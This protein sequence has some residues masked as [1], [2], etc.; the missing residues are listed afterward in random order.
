V[1]QICNF[2]DLIYDANG[3]F[4]FI[5]WV[6]FLTNGKNFK[7]LYMVDDVYCTHK[8]ELM[9]SSNLRTILHKEPDAIQ[10]N[11]LAGGRNSRKLIYLELVEG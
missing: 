2:S 5:F 10:L 7:G 1:E 3:L 11:V 6:K 8:R 4:P 9:T